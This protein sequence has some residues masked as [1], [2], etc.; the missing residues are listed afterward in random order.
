MK[1]AVCA[2][3][4]ALMFS[5]LVPS[6]FAQGIQSSILN[7]SLNGKWREAVEVERDGIAPGAQVF[8]DESTGTVLQ[9]RNDFQIRAVTE[10]SQQFTSAGQAG[11]T[12]EA[13][14]ILMLTM[15][16]LP[17]KYSQSIAGAIGEG[18]V[19]RMWEVKDPGNAQW[20]YVSQLFGGYHV[21]GGNQSSEVSEEYVPLRA[22]RAEHKTVG[23]GDALIFEAETDKAAPEVAI[24]RFKLPATLKDQRLRYGWIQFSPGG[25]ASSES[26]ISLAFATP[27]NSGIDV[28][29]VLDQVVKNY[30][31]KTGAK[32]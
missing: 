11:T 31:K 3:V 14:K 24:K 32:E 9:M 15:F 13:A 4:S 28:N 18:H 21:K 27:V 10:I 2:I 22:T 17:S 6:I 20:F 30:A 12:P 8:Y 16:P 29:A 1:K 7:L 26:I 23:N 5:F 25:I 19:P